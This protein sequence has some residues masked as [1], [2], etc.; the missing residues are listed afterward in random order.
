MGS[1]LIQISLQ[2]SGDLKNLAT[3]AKKIERDL[4]CITT[5]IVKHLSPIH[6]FADQFDPLFP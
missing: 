5:A 4:L 6:Y 2:D 1:L 3:L